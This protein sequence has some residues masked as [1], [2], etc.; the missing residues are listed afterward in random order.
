MKST[1][2]LQILAAGPQLLCL[3]GF[4]VARSGECRVLLGARAL[5]SV[6]RPNRSMRPCEKPWVGEGG[7]AVCSGLFLNGTG[8]SVGVFVADGLDQYQ[9]PCLY[10][11]S[12]LI[13]VCIGFIIMV[14]AI[15]LV[16][17]WLHY[18]NPLPFFEKIVH[19][20]IPCYTA[21]GGYPLYG[22]FCWCWE[23]V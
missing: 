13:V 18:F 21:A 2:S 6:L 22:H 20:L 23:A 17:W 14:L 16:I 4:S 15:L 8:W 3:W 19:S 1:A 7:A 10:S 12:L 11:A 9:E 5:E